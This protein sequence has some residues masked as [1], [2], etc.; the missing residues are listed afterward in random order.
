MTVLFLK[1]EST[2]KYVQYKSTAKKMVRK[3]YG[4]TTLIINVLCQIR[5]FVLFF[6]CFQG[7]I[8]VV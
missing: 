7:N 8:R 6:L 4:C 3:K 2:K 1:K 5:T